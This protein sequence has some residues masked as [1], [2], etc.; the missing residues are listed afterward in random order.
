MIA[1]CIIATHEAHQISVTRAITTT[2][3]SLLPTAF[4]LGATIR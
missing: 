1:A 2:V 3:V 4:I